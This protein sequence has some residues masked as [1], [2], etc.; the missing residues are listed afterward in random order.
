M[1]WTVTMLGWFKAEAARASRSS[2][3]SRSRSAESSAGRTLTA[4]WRPRRV[5]SARKTS[6]I[7]PE[8]SGAMTSYG[9]SRVPGPTGLPSAGLEGPLI[10]SGRA[11]GP[12][13]W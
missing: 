9:P 7:P 10:A 11:L 2:R 3:A 1:S 4:T 12:H 5:S 8:P 6:P 13:S